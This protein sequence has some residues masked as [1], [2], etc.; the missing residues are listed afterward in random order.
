LRVPRNERVVTGGG[1]ASNGNT[2]PA[3]GGTGTWGAWAGEGPRGVRGPQGGGKPLVSPPVSPRPDPP[4]GVWSQPGLAKGRDLLGPRC[5]RGPARGR[6]SRARLKVIQAPLVVSPTRGTRRV[7]AHAPG[8]P[9]AAHPRAR[10]GFRHSRKFRTGFPGR[11]GSGR[12][13]PRSGKVPLGP[14]A[15]G[16]LP[17]G[18]P[19]DH[20]RPGDVPRQAQ[21]LGPGRSSCPRPVPT[22]GARRP[23]GRRR[24]GV[25]GLGGAPSGPGIPGEHLGTQVLLPL[26]GVPSGPMPAGPPFAARGGGKNAL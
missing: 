3:P 7:L 25:A 20:G 5:P 17:C 16:P 1:T 2:V 19:P 21:P 22:Q 14:A 10:V 15:P 23:L 24:V 18:P 13:G 26:R 8:A 4:P 6:P 12:A 9:G 11:A